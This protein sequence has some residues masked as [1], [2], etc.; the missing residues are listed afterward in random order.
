MNSSD[1]KTAV[2][3][4]REL[5]QSTPD[6]SSARALLVLGLART[7]ALEEAL[8]H[9]KTLVGEQP[10]AAE[11]HNILAVIY[12]ALGQASEAQ[13]SFEH[14]LKLDPT[15]VTAGLNLARLHRKGKRARAA[16]DVYQR[17]RAAHPTHPKI[18]IAAAPL[19]SDDGNVKPALAMLDKARANN[20]A[21]VSP[22]MVLANFAFRR[23]DADGAKR[24]LE[25]AITSAPN[26]P[27]VR[28]LLARAYALTGN[29]PKGISMYEA[30]A[31]RFSAPAA[32]HYQ[33][34]LAYEMSGAKTKMRTS[35]E[36]TIDADPGHL[37]AAVA[38]A[39]IALSD[40][41]FDEALERGKALAARHEKLPAG[42]VII[43]DALL[44]K[45]APE[46]AAAAFARAFA[47]APGPEVVVRRTNAMAAA[48]RASEGIA[49]A[50]EWLRTEHAG[51]WRVRLSI[52]AALT[53]A[54]KLQQA[55]I[56]YERVLYTNPE[57]VQATNNLAWL[58]YLQKD[59]RSVETAKRAFELA[60]KRAN[61]L[62]TYGWI[63]IESSRVD[64]GL[65]I[66]DTA[67][68]SAPGA[69]GIRMHRALGLEK[70]GQL[71]KA[72]EELKFLA[73]SKAPQSVHKQ[74]TERLTKL[75]R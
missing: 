28:W 50:R 1:A 47:L 13:S 53:N 34:A 7:G 33:L 62:D 44:A 52:A 36:R 38:L 49:F 71:H 37:G 18:L 27:N 63:L 12:H 26:N 59:A 43:A 6:F 42:H 2:P 56:E 32:M 48:G 72:R 16:R 58:Y 15:F 3:K 57:N 14:A 75:A 55:I 68:E 67:I 35:F 60:P 8:Q 10:D 19:E 74:A 21:A 64:E 5:L 17:L 73:Q 30:L 51:D 46:Q 4:L 31:E 39:N 22:R 69:F 61:V 24:L 23:G 29:L 41:A 40:G 66:L 11:S 45:G 70:A 54:G 25:E 20:P 9:A 65:R